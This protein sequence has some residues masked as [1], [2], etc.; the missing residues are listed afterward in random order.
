M[1]RFY[2]AVSESRDAESNLVVLEAK[3]RHGRFLA[4]VS[5]ETKPKALEALKDLVLEMLLDQAEDLQNPL[6]GLYRKHPQKHEGMEMF[7]QELFPT[8]LRYQR[9]RHG[10]TQSAV[11]AELAMTQQVYARLE[12]PG[13]ANPTLTTVQ[14]L[15]RALNED[16]LA[17]V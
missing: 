4:V 11:A 15:E 12:K 6:E 3:D 8:L 5:E 17:L 16:L 14:R 7:S 1:Q 2:V 13:Q 9:C 10:L